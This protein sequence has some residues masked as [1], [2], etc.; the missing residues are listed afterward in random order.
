MLPS[1][2]V[3]QGACQGHSR[4]RSAHQNNSLGTPSC[5]RQ[6][7]K[8]DWD[9]LLPYSCL[10]LCVLISSLIW[11]FST[12]AIEK[13]NIIALCIP[14]QTTRCKRILTH[15]RPAIEKPTRG[16]YAWSPNSLP[17]QTHSHSWMAPKRL[18][19]KPTQVSDHFHDFKKRKHL[20]GSEF[21][22]CNH[23]LARSPKE[24]FSEVRVHTGTTKV[25]FEI[26]FQIPADSP[27]GDH[28][29]TKA[30]VKEFRK[31]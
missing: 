24:A 8:L 31:N 26:D 16:T 4:A 21:S 9:S 10:Q 17:S 12:Y 20:L 27:P 25:D 28:L 22:W 29:I 15:R 13:A 7:A 30:T 3:F 18:P 11:L 1:R 6:T 2:K 19:D 14:I 23:R 5:H